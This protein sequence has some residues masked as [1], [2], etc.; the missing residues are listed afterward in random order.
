MKEYTIDN[1]NE[2]FEDLMNKP[3]AKFNMMRIY[4]AYKREGEIEKRIDDIREKYKLTSNY[5]EVY[6]INEDIAIVELQDC[7]RVSGYCAHVNNKK[8]VYVWN[9]FE[10][11]LLCAVSIKLTGRED[12]TE[13][14]WKLVGGE[15]YLLTNCL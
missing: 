10:Q 5:C 13:W 2:F 14:M 6:I 15:T 9:T 8:A 1:I 11:A 12:A 3:N 7:G 4:G